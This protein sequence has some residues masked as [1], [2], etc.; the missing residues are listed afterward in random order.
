MILIKQN[1]IGLSSFVYNK[2]IGYQTD[3]YIGDVANIGHLK[4]PPK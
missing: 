3:E 4:A 1:T 2:G